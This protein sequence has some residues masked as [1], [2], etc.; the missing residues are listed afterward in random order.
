M[1]VKI[2]NKRNG[3]Y[4]PPKKKVNKRFWIVYRPPTD[5]FGY[6]FHHFNPEQ[7]KIM[8]ENLKHISD[9]DLSLQKL[10]DLYA[11][12]SFDRMKREEKIPDHDTDEAFIEILVE[13]F[14]ASYPFQEMFHKKYMHD[15]QNKDDCYYIWSS[16]GEYKRMMKLQG[17]SEALD[18]IYMARCYQK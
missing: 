16:V 10:F 6:D 9:K 18:T 5:L 1:P 17:V 14:C 3:I 7:L 12:Y 15:N 8:R 11:I 4:I 2:I 13:N